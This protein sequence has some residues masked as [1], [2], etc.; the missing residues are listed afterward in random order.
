MSVRDNHTEVTEFILVGFPGSLGLHACLLALF[1]LAYTLTLTENLLIIAVIRASPALHKPMYVFLSHLSFLEVCYVSVTEPKM[2]LSL[3]APEFRRISFAGCM[4][5]LYFFLALAC[6]ECALLAAMAFDRYVAVCSPLRY[7]AI[8][9]P[10]LCSLLAAA[11]WCSGFAVSLGKVF[12]ISRLGYCGPNVM[13]HFFCDVSPLL[14]LACSDMSTAELMDFLLALLIL[15]GP[16]LLTASSYAAILRALLRIPSAAG[17]QKAFSTCASHLAV[18]AIFYSA[19]LFI[20]ARPRAIY[21]FEYNKLVSV[22]YTVLTPLANPVIYCLRNQEVKEALRRA[23]QAL[24][25]SS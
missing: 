2:L 6:T 5:Q 8:V 4:A 14:N 9:G 20:Y 23:A 24:G 7:P 3:A 11:S 1:L 22:V 25:A 21:S 12:F 15:L 17:R 18:V 13:N 10:R 16:L 19:S